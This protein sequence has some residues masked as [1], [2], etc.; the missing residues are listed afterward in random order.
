MQLPIIFT[1]KEA[2]KKNSEGKIHMENMVNIAIFVWGHLL[3]LRF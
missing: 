3:N 2:I 1:I